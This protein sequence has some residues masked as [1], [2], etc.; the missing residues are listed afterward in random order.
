[1]YICIYVYTCMYIY[2]HI[3]IYTYAYMYVNVK[4]YTWRIVEP[5]C[6]PP[7]GRRADLI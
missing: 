7:G 1:M 6:P 4:I 3:Y 5:L 2:L